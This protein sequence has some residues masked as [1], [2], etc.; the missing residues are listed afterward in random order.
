MRVAVVGAG[1]SGLAALRALT[2]EGID[3]VAF[4]KGERVGGVWTLEERPTAAYRTLHLITSRERTEFGEYPLPAGTPDYPSAQI[5]GAYLERYVEQYGL[6]DRIRLGAGVEHCERLADGGWRVEGE[7]FSHL[8]IANGHNAVAKWPDPPYPGEFEGEQVHALDYEDAER[9]RG[10][11]VMV[12]GMGNSAMDIATDLSHSA[13]RTLLSVRHGSWVIPKRLLGQPA[14]QITSPWMA[15][16]VPWK[17]RQPISE[18]LL[19]ITV[20][21]PERYG[22]PKPAHGLFEGHP[23]ITDT[24]LSRI[25]HGEIEPKPGIREFEGGSVRFTDGGAEEADAIVWCT[26]YV[27][28][29]PML[30]PALVGGDPRELPLYKRVFHLDAPDLFFVGLMQ[31]TGSAFPI[32]ERQSQLVA[33]RLTGRFALP[34]VPEMRADVAKRRAAAVARWGERGRPGMRVD[35]DRFMYEL[36]QELEA[37]RGRAA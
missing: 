15:V 20:G 31:S 19:K 35:F 30:D 13:Q 21:S 6:G 33:E 34:S 23:T 28:E 10:K 5:I 1:P 32:V 27:V 2:R 11:R 18:A 37:G 7:E 12:V 8:V 14:D 22:L 36:G 25:S 24:V 29:L 9:F 16:H 17:I 26:G 3:A 4:E